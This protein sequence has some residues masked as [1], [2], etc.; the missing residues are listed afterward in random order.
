MIL[1]KIWGTACVLFVASALSSAA[2]TGWDLKVT[3]SSDRQWTG[4][5]VSDQGR[6]FVNYPYWSEDV[7]VR[8][9]EIVDGRAVP[10]PSPEWNDRK[11]PDAFNAVQSVVIDAEDRLWVLDTN[12]PQ[13]NGVQK[14]GPVLFQFDLK[15]NRKVMAFTFPEGV[16]LPN[17][18]FN[19]V[20]IDTEKEI[21]YITDSGNGAL[22]VLNLATG[23]SRRLL[24]THPSVKSE[25]DYLVC[26]GVVWNNS[27]DSDG[28][29]LTR[30]GE[31]LYYIALTGH[32]LYRIKTD[33]LNDE[34]LSPEELT[35]EVE[36]VA[37]VPA[38]D[39]I[40]FDQDGNL[41]LGGLENHAVNMIDPKG[42]LIR[43]LQDP[44]IRWA[45][46]FAMD[47]KGNIY[48]TTSQI[49]LPEKDRGP[50]QVLSF[51]PGQ[52]HGKK[53]LNK[54]LMA[55]TSHGTLGENEGEPTGYYLSEVS[56]AYYAFKEAGFAV[57]FTSPLGGES[58]VTGL[59]V[60]D[61]ENTRFLNDETAQKAIQN[62]IPAARV[63]A[64]DYRAVYYAGG[65][66]T[67]WDFPGNES[68]QIISRRIYETGGVVSAVC[69]GPAGLVD[70]R[71]SNGKFL[72]EGKNVST[73]TNAEEAAV[74]LDKTVPF[75]LES[76][77]I[78]RG[79]HVER[80]ELFQ[81]KTVVDQRL[82]TGQNPA[83]AKAVA[84]KTLRLLGRSMTT[85]E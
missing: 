40:M 44:D 35:R 8:V 25:I 22:I 19:D 43:V 30:N 24:D 47:R 5:A 41:W 66:G 2:D 55:I 31:Y 60:E 79:A 11:S 77:L 29:A 63:N 59:E 46:S 56:H 80:A 6:I 82:V 57:D 73:F 27:V 51:N 42:N 83:S 85:S 13:F 20:R 10:Y 32:T 26:D 69:H 16:Y 58:P 4:V 9:A 72:V 3:A 39:G 68:L 67:M 15:N 37:S 17:S 50:Y 54:I 18:Y 28:I 23:S 14:T 33:A 84:R 38:T 61:E 65:H 45:D 62:S 21:A 78:E 64:G 81:E 75:A 36:A 76:R 1:R 34:S 70:I 52:V 12:N 49:H 74:K 71:L 53:K 48:F 7:P